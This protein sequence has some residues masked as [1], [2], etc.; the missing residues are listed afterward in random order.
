[1]QNVLPESNDIRIYQKLGR[2]DAKSLEA[3][4]QLLLI[5]P[6]RP[7]KAAFSR[8]PQGAKM[9]AVYRRH[10]VGSVPAFTTRLGNRRQTLVIAGT[11]GADAST[12][13]QLT[14]ARQLVAAATRQKAGSIGICAAGFDA[15]TQAKFVGSV[16]AAVLAAGFSMPEFKA[17][18][19]PKT[20]SSIRLV[21]LAEKLDTSRL[22]AEAHGNNLAR[23]LTA[24]PPNIL[25]ANAY[26]KLAGDLAKEHD[27]QYKRFTTR[28]LRKLGCGAFL[29]VAQGND[30]DSASIV[31]LRYRPAAKTAAPDLSLVG[32]GII[33]D[34]GGTNLKPFEGML[35]MHGDMQGSAVALGTLLAISK[36]RLPVA[37]DC[38][39]AITENR[40]GPNAYKSQDVVTAANG[41]TIQTVHT[42]AEG[43]MALADT[44]V[45]AS[46]ETP[47]IIIDYATLTGSC[48]RALTTRYTGV[49]TNR[50]ELHARL[51]EIG[52]QSGERVWPFPIGAE[53]MDDLQS[54][55]ADFLQCAVK[56]PGDHI[57]AASFL[58]EFVENDVPWVHLDLSAGDNDKGLGH[59]ATKFTGFGVR[60]TLGA[61]LDGNLLKAKA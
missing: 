33:F 41:K 1:M 36:L 48:V 29:A 27:W 40:T 57:H 15:A 10:A 5:L 34:T 39:L 47:G 26:A 35:D 58:A 6:A 9:Q 11:L 13:E 56:S 53:F 61:M 45:L 43:R 52:E 32:K 17:K 46:R 14:L 49:F 50:P 31:R 25:D 4:D 30:N 55:T 38:W 3:V 42:D 23:W 8:L 21:G 44:L 2:V 59:I 51:T 28:E 37:V 16:L 24:L 19:S 7:G 12:F 18:P 22:E 60:Y 54:D 20:V